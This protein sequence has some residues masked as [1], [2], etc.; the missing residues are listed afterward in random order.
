M[1]EERQPKGLYTKERI[2]FVVWEAW[3]REYVM[4]FASLGKKLY[5]YCEG[6]VFP[7]ELLL[8]S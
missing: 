6:L 3:D 7:R 1:E 4:M 8:P 2:L 5:S